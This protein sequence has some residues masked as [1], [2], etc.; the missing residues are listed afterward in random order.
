MNDLF[1]DKLEDLL[2]KIVSAGYRIELLK[3]RV[4]VDKSEKDLGISEVWY[5][6]LLLARVTQ[7]DPTRVTVEKF[8]DLTPKNKGN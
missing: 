8:V 3:R 4:L 1:A 7:V 2:G 6:E 5:G